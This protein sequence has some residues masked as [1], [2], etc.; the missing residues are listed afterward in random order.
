MITA[1]TPSAQ[2]RYLFSR[3]P[4]RGILEKGCLIR[5]MS[6]VLLLPDIFLLFARSVKSKMDNF[7]CVFAV[8]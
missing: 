1:E 7:L 3:I 8:K 4:E 2:R 5:T 6:T